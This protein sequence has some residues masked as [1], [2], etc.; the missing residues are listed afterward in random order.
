MADATRF[1]G[2]M[3]VYEVVAHVIVDRGEADPETFSPGT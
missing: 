2:R 3:R 1:I